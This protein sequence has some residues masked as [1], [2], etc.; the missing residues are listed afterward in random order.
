MGEPVAAPE[1]PREKLAE[2]KELEQLLYEYQETVQEAEK[3]IASGM[4]KNELDQLRREI[5]TLKA[6]DQ[7]KEIAEPLSPEERKLMSLLLAKEKLDPIRKKISELY[8]KNP[9]KR[10][11]LI[12]AI[13]KS[14]KEKGTTDL[15]LIADLM[16]A[17]L[18]QGMNEMVKKWE[19]PND[20]EKK[21]IK[22]GKDGIEAYPNP[23]YTS[24]LHPMPQEMVFNMFLVEEMNNPKSEFKKI[25]ED[26]QQKKEMAQFPERTFAVFQQFVKAKGL[27]ADQFCSSLDW[28]QKLCLIADV[29]NRFEQYEAA[30][31]PL[32]SRALGIQPDMRYF[33]IA[34]LP[35]RGMNAAVDKLGKWIKPE[36]LNDPTRWTADSMLLGA[37]QLGGALTVILNVG[38]A[39][40][41][42]VWQ[43]GKMIK[44]LAGFDLRQALHHIPLIGKDAKKALKESLPVGRILIAGAG[45]FVAQGYLDPER[46]DQWLQSGVVKE[47]FIDWAA[48]KLASPTRTGQEFLQWCIE[49]GNKISIDGLKE[50]M[51]DYLWDPVKGAATWVGEKAPEKWK[52]LETW[53]EKLPFV[54][55]YFQWKEYRKHFEV[56]NETRTF[57]ASELTKS[58]DTLVEK[59][60]S[61]TREGF[62]KFLIEYQKRSAS[63]KP[64][65][66]LSL[67]DLVVAGFLKV[68]D[69]KDKKEEERKDKKFV[70]GK[71]LAEK[72]FEQ[73]RWLKGEKKFH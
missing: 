48:L 15:V 60:S 58:D 37:V 57:I 47:G 25:M 10:E 72:L 62:E 50:V 55:G 42:Q 13:F 28:Y 46:W 34:G 68:D 30:L 6:I 56:L 41:G 4:A 45:Y 33:P 70:V 23:P 52:E 44:S 53:S 39:I 9:D 21:K 31:Q 18:R 54:A 14:L 7:G 63:E 22:T 24:K 20:E 35:I 59:L 1:R 65:P 16:Q 8:Q 61:G 27:E 26:L 66:K 32:T 36:N 51:V 29:K 3:R 67:E 40:F 12:D 19:N 38:G 5:R 43:G 64:Y 2:V 17:N 69:V 71:D 49:K 73:A 11:I